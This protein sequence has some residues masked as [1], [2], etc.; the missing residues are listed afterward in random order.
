IFTPHLMTKK[1]TNNLSYI[2]ATIALVVV[3]GG[4]AWAY[5]S[6]KLLQGRMMVPTKFNEEQLREMLKNLRCPGDFVSVVISDVTS[7]IS[8][9]VTSQ[10]TSDVTS[11]V[12]TSGGPTE[13]TSQVP[14]N[15]TSLVTS[16]VTSHVPQC[17]PSKKKKKPTDWWVKYVQQ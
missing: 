15:V 3:L 2:V 5:S 6:G 9:E 1:K 7:E 10:V 16:Q 4:V 17:V 8:T 14:S 12:T 11:I 13:V